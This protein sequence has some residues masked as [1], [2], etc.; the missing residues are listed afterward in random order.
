M[1]VIFIISPPHCTGA[2]APCQERG[3]VWRR[4]GNEEEFPFRLPVLE[5]P[6]GVGSLRQR[7]G[8]VDA[9][10]QRAGVNPGQYV[11]SPREQL[12]PRMGVMMKG[13]PGQKERP[14]RI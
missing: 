4:S 9:Q 13:R 2:A 3:V 12:L 6:V 10:T 8:A 5:I 7:K 14:L 11:A 1:K